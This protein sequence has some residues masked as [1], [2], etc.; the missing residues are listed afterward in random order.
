MIPNF[1]VRDFVNL[2]WC[3]KN[4]D[5]WK[6]EK[7]FDDSVHLWNEKHAYDHKFL[8]QSLWNDKITWRWMK[9]IIS[10]SESSNP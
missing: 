3:Q 10:A 7:N 9:H 1:K 6:C 8:N 2:L 4:D 5:F